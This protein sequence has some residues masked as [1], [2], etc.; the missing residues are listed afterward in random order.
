MAMTIAAIATT[1]SA[2]HSLSTSELIAI[3]GFSKN[4]SIGYRSGF[5]VH[6]S[7]CADE[8]AKLPSEKNQWVSPCIECFGH[9]T[10]YNSVVSAI[11]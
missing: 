6:E 3:S 2:P 9:L 7:S 10:H 8:T 1:P 5:N 11:V 4:L